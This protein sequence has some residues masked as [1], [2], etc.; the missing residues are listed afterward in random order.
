VAESGHRVV[1]V[2]HGMTRSLNRHCSPSVS[3][4]GRDIGCLVM[5]V[6]GYQVEADCL[7][8]CGGAG[9]YTIILLRCRVPECPGVSGPNRGVGVRWGHGDIGHV[10][11]AA[12]FAVDVTRQELLASCLLEAGCRGDE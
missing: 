10:C 8:A 5:S 2:S 1:R 4:R 3:W 12:V 7:R 11:T 6:P 9:G